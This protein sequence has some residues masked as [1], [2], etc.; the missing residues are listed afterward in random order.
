MKRFFTILMVLILSCGACLL[1]A[2]G[3][4]GGNTNPSGSD[5]PQ[6]IDL[7]TL[8]KEATEK[9]LAA[10]NYE[11]K[12]V[13]VVDTDMF[14]I[15][16]KTTTEMTFLC[17]GKEVGIDGKSIIELADSKTETP[18]KF[19]YDGAYLYLTILG[20][21]YKMAA[22]EEEF[23][24]EAGNPGEHIMVLPE[25]LFEGVTG[26]ADKVELTVDDATLKSLYGEAIAEEIS[27]EAEDLSQVTIK[28]GKITISV[29]DG[30]LATFNV[31]FTCE[32]AGGEEDEEE[33][34]TYTC[35]QTTEFV[36]YGGVTV[37]PLEGYEDF[38]AVDDD[39]LFGDDEIILDDDEILFDED[40]VLIYED[41]ELLVYDDDD[42]LFEDEP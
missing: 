16:T 7:Y 3:D 10:T 25:A 35:S 21:G 1:T 24:D 17:N 29:K 38:T 32:I 26:T 42:F 14:G 8:V 5:E 37:T 19:Y 34:A 9:T 23:T 31:A 39:F 11:A 18:C 33:T 41:D 40:D 30:Y 22:T 6:T 28:D 27:V 12:A 15:Q 20:E 13:Y 2:C 36:R 4:T